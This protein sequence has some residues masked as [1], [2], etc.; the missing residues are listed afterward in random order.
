VRQGS[1]EGRWVRFERVN[2]GS[3]RASKGR[4]WE[5]LGLDTAEGGNGACLVCIT[6]GGSQP[7]CSYCRVGGGQ[8]RSPGRRGG[9]MCREELVG[10]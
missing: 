2:L 9:G 4:R 1:D 7:S 3:W 6:V 10:S 8:L 5:T